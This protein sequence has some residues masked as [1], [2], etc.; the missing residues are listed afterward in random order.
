MCKTYGY[1]GRC[2]NLV[3]SVAVFLDGTD[4]VIVVPSATYE[5]YGR[6]C[7]CITQCIPS[8]SAATPV[9][10]QFGFAATP[11]RYPLLANDGT[12]PIY[13]YQLKC[14]KRYPV[15]V[16]S[17][18]ASLIIHPRQ[19]EAGSTVISATSA[20]TPTPATFSTTTKSTGGRNGTEK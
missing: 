4:M 11:T 19:L 18:S 12:T 7:L 6:L 16:G 9:F 17:D 5:T 14:R 2:N 13:S 3:K 8:T 20:A 15:T 1:C 10:V